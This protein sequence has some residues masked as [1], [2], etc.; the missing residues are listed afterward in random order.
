[1]ETQIFLFFDGMN[2]FCNKFSN[3]WRRDSQEKFVFHVFSGEKMP[4]PKKRSIA[5]TT[6]TCLNKSFFGC[7]RL[8]EKAQELWDWLRQLEEEKYDHEQRIARQKYDVSVV[9]FCKLEKGWVWIQ[10]R[11]NS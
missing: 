3:M 1:M 2:K 4:V 9:L 7:F 11:Q 8:R 10:L 5:L 6:Y